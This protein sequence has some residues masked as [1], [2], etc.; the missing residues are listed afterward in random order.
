MFSSYIN[1]GI[2]PKYGQYDF[3]ENN[4]LVRGQMAVETDE[5]LLNAKFSTNVMSEQNIFLRVAPWF[6]KKQAMK[7][8]FKFKGDPQSSTTISN[9]GSVSLPSE[10]ARVCYADGFY[11][12]PVKPKSRGVRMPELRRAVDPKF[13]PT[14]WEPEVE[15]T[16]FTSLV[17]MGLHVKIES[18]SNVFRPRSET[19]FT[20]GADRHVLL[21]KL[22]RGIGAF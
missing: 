7:L 1:P 22:R 9:L 21:C 10:M 5:K 12:W 11:A 17:K 2:E 13:H 4:R 19:G 20:K 3:S 6:L 14:I 8:V 18:N 16:F 15:Q